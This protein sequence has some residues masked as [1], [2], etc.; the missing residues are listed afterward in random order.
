MNNKINR[1]YKFKFR[2]IRLI[3]KRL[4]V[5]QCIYIIKSL[6]RLDLSLF[7]TIKYHY[8]VPHR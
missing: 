3:K 4:N 5:Y 1:I 6:S 2:F 8:Y 7:I